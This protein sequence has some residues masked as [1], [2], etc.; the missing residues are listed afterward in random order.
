ML[1]VD[2]IAGAVI[3]GMVAWGIW[4]GLSGTI[5]LAA[6]A[7]GALV[8]AVM[9]PFALQDGNEDEFALVFALPAALL[10]GALLAT[11]LERRTLRLRR[12]LDRRDRLDPVSAVG[13]ALLGAWIGAVAVWFAGTVALQVGGLR[14]PVEDSA[15]VSRLDA[16]L[17]LPGPGPAQESRPGRPPIAAEA[18][19]GPPIA[20]VDPRIVDDPQVRSADRSVVKIGIRSDCDAVAGSGWIAADGV[21]VMDAYVAA[22]ADVI[23]VRVGGRGPNH[24]ATLIWF[25]HDSGVAL[26]R[27]P[28]LEGVPALPIVSSPRR[29]TAGAALGFPGG[30]RDILPARIGPTTLLTEKLL[31]GPPDREFPRTGLP[32]TFIR[33]G[34]RVGSSGGPVVDAGGRVLTTVIGGI[35]AQSRGFGI[36][37]RVVRS[38]LRRA[39]PRVDTGGCPP[40]SADARER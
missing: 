37:N 22:G 36:P 6:F 13:G 2:L 15:I 12:S 38:A 10:L 14:N 24:R 39:G 1:I 18:G 34:V 28:A 5:A 16:V 23:T 11:L 8:G 32:I 3:A 35:E 25:G 33:A 4:R 7:A 19:G 27:A 29:G 20:P 40:S 30:Q 31:G 17:T 21:V 26:L 9:A